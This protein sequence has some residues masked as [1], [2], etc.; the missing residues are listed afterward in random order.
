MGVRSALRSSAFQDTLLALDEA[1]DRRQSLE[2][3]M[4]KENKLGS[5]AAEADFWKF[6]DTQLIDI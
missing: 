3:L 1:A 4:E 2:K 6:V 5:G